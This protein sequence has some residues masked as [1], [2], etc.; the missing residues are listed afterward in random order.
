[1]KRSLLK[2]KCDAA[3]QPIDPP[4]SAAEVLSAMRSLPMLRAGASTGAI[5]D[6]TPFLSP[7]FLAQVNDARRLYRADPQGVP[8]RAFLSTLVDMIPD[9]SEAA[10][11]VAAA[12]EGVPVKFDQEHGREYVPVRGWPIV[13]YFHQ[14]RIDRS[15]TTPHYDRWLRR[16]QRES[17]YG[18]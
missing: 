12:L 17:R 13:Y 5:T 11:R 14:G 2:Q 15:H 9:T 4:T 10:I 16:T 1:M 7:E 18:R 6:L 8:R 3:L